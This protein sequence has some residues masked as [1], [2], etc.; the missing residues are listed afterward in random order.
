[1]HIKFGEVLTLASHRNGFD[2]QEPQFRAAISAGVRKAHEQ[3]RTEITP[4]VLAHAFIQ[5]NEAEGTVT[6]MFGAGDQ[7]TV[8]G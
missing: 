3:G 8:F 6:F 4:D 2:D 1:V 5:R 7:I